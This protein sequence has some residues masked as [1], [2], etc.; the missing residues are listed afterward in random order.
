MNSAVLG[1]SLACSRMVLIAIL[2]I[3]RDM[4]VTGLSEI[5]FVVLRHLFQVRTTILKMVTK[6]TKSGQGGNTGID[7][8]IMSVS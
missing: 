3:L 8:S 5:I 1:G 7:W 6:L 2:A 4:L